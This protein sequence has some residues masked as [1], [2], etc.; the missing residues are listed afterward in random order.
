MD[1]V[2]MEPEVDPLAIGININ[3]DINEQKILCQVGNVLHLQVT[4]IKTE[5]MDHSYGLNSEMAFDETP[6]PI[7]F[8][9]MKSE[10]EVSTVYEEGDVLYHRMTQIKME[11]MDNSYE[12]TFDETPVPIDFPIVKYEAEEQACEIKLEVT[13]EED[14]VLTQRK[15]PPGSPPVRRKQ[16]RDASTDANAIEMGV[17]T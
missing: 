15:Q 5:C 2:K 7:N 14:E 1:V 10:V 11:C 6:V 4:G 8:P 3:S 13:A 16:T 9:V 17:M 12:M